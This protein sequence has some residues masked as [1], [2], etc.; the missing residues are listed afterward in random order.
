MVTVLGNVVSIAG[1]DGLVVSRT[2]LVGVR[3]LC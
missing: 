3:L 1:V 2:C